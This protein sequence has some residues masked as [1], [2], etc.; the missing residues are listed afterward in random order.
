MHRIQVQLTTRQEKAL[1][2]LARLRGS[3]ISALIRDGIDH[4]LEPSATARAEKLARARKAIG[5]FESGVT[6]VSER[7][8]AYL[9]EAFRSDEGG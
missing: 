5:A 6:D 2:E 8:D 1:R 9:A 4:I 7:H 3:S